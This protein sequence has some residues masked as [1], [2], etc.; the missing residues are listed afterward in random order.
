[1]VR[2]S[3]QYSPCL[4]VDT[5]DFEIVSKYY[6]PLLE[7]WVKRESTLPDFGLGQY[8]VWGVI[9]IVLGGSPELEN[10]IRA[11]P[12]PIHYAHEMASL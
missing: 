1:M 8:S 3:Y 5:A 4:Y 9:D 6:V 10:F 11:C 12:T 7:H 2:F